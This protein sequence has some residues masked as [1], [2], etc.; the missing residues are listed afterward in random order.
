MLNSEG[1][2]SKEKKNKE[3]A[4]FITCRWKSFCI[5][6]ISISIKL[7]HHITVSCPSVMFNYSG[8]SAISTALIF[9]TFGFLIWLCKENTTE[10]FNKVICNLCQLTSISLQNQG[11]ITLHCFIVVLHELTL[12][13]ELELNYWINSA[14]WIVCIT[15]GRYKSIQ[16]SVLIGSLQV[17]VKPCF[18]WW[19]KQYAD[20]IAVW[21]LVTTVGTK[22]NNQQQ[23]TIP[24]YVICAYM[25]LHHKW[26][27]GLNWFEWSCQ[28]YQADDT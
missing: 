16:Q 22:G 13:D 12:A 4:S 25:C 6:I 8:G 20:S 9:S 5:M 26:K 11:L 27:Q 7:A 21:S 14:F 17:I 19:C 23:G 2:L 15:T 24:A 1:K 28:C 10:K 3:L 18:Q